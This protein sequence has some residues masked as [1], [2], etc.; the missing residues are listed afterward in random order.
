[1]GERQTAIMGRKVMQQSY[2]QDLARQIQMKSSS[3][4][5][6]AT[7]S[8]DA[9]CTSL[10]FQPSES[11]Q[12]ACYPR[13]RCPFQ[14]SKQVLQVLCCLESSLL[15]ETIV[16]STSAVPD[17][18]FQCT[19]DWSICLTLIQ[20]YKQQLLQQI[21]DRVKAR[22][23][24]RQRDLVLHQ[25]SLYGDSALEP[26]RNTMSSASQVAAAQTASHPLPLGVRSFLDA[27]YV[28]NR[29]L[30]HVV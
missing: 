11:S 6:S 1:M 21:T 26:Q 19:Y 28:S 4:H 16:R 24:E 14:I 7:H 3:H 18:F 29:E 17:V 13:E 5:A 15:C 8:S 22:Q 23:Q 12:A 10:N 2:A 30:Q 20:E 27:N 25:N 9:V